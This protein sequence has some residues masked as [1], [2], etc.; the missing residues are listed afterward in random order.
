M[1]QQHLKD[2]NIQTLL[3]VLSDLYK[4]FD[5]SLTK[6]IGFCVDTCHV[7]AAG[8]CDLRSKKGIHTFIK[9][10]HENIGWDKVELIHFNDSKCDFKSKKDRHAPMGQGFIG[11]DTLLYFR[12]LCILT[13]KPMV[14]EYDYKKHDFDAHEKEI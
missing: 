9:T 3:L 11:T 12:K 8:E 1:K 13:N 10:W 6:H 14:L 4:T 7:F 5:P 2:Q